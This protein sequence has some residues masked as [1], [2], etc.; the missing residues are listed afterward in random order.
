M[1]EEIKNRVAESKLITIDLEDVYP[2]GQ[3]VELDISQW[4]FDGSILREK[5]FREQLK[6]YSWEQYQDSYIALSNKSE[7][8][9]PAWAFMLISI[10]LNPFAK[11]IIIGTLE[12]LETLLYS[13]I[14]SSININDFKDKSVIIKGCANKPIPENAYIL[15]TQKLQPVVKSVMYGE[16]CSAVPLFKKK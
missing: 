12:Q 9:L 5:D 16:A 15:L 13:D 2:K 8:I 7:A 3:R 10:Q 14:I 4:L 6:K 11:K 1:G